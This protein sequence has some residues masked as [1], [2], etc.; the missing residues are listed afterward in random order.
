MMTIVSVAAG[1]FLSRH[2]LRLRVFAMAMTAAAR[3]GRRFWLVRA[4]GAVAGGRPTV[5]M[6]LV[7]G[8]HVVLTV[9]MAVAGWFARVVHTSGD[10]AEP[11]ILQRKPVP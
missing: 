2:G 11:P 8:V 1:S 3:L 6:R 5:L 9:M 7:T 10:G 4:M